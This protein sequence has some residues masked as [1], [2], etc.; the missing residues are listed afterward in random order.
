MS[1]KRIVGDGWQMFE[2]VW[3][4][5]ISLCFAGFINGRS[6]VGVESDLGWSWVGVGS[7]LGR[8]WV[9]V[10]SAL[11]RSWVGVESELGRSWDGV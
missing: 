7:E 4:S 6:G 11:S 2:G 3:V 10:G 8:S 5:A 9:G 1:A